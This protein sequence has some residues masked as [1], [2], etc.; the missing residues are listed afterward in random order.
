MADIKHVGKIKGSEQ[1]LL[2]PYRTVPGDSLNQQ[3]L[4]NSKT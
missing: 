3:L 1:K 2:W 4:F